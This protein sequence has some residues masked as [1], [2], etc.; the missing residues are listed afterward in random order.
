MAIENADDSASFGMQIMKPMHQVQRWR[1]RS[2]LA[3]PGRPKGD[4]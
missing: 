1:S 2:Q 4:V 3:L